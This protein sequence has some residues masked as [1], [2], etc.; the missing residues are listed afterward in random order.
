MALAGG[1]CLLNQ[2][3]R[4]ISGRSLMQSQSRSAP[5]GKQTSSQAGDAALGSYDY[6]L[7]AITCFVWGTSWLALRMQLGTIAPEV[8]LVWRFALAGLIVFAWAAIKR[9][10]LAFSAQDHLIFFGMG[11]FIFST[12]FAL[13]YYGGLTITAGLLAVIFSLASVI[14]FLIGIVFFGQKPEPRRLVGAGLGAVGIGFLFWPEIAGT[15]FDP[16]ALVAL[17]LC[18]L[19]TLFFC[20]G[21][22]MSARAQRRGLPILATNAWG[23]VY[24]TLWLILLALVQGH[25][26]TIEPNGRYLGSLVWLAVFS[27]VIAFW[28]YL[29]LLGRIG[30]ARAAYATVIF[31]LVAL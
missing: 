5:T 24:G 26:F 18:V 6:T 15:T 4:C 19:G 27:S 28:S 1:R 12:N 14:N 17:G 21:N 3:E 25:E 9:E 30:G 10:R 31:P 7:F 8:S 16:Q 29:T 2:Q 13:F 23:M 11:L 20:I 22:V